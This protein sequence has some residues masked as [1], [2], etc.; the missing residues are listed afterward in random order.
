MDSER[1]ISP[2]SSKPRKRIRI[3][4][5]NQNMFDC[6]SEVHVSLLE[7]DQQPLYKAY[8]EAYANLLLLWGM[9]I[10]H[11]EVLKVEV[12]TEFHPDQPGNRQEKSS[13]PIRQEHQ[14]NE[15][16]SAPPHSYAHDGV[17][18]QHHCAKCGTA[19]LAPSNPKQNGEQLSQRKT[20]RNLPSAARC[21]QCSP[22]QPIAI[23]TACIICA[24]VIRGMFTPC[25]GCGH[26]ACL[27]CHRRWFTSAPSSDGLRGGS[28]RYQMPSCATG[29]GCHCAEHVEVEMPMPPS[30]PPPPAVTEEQPISVPASPI[31][32][33]RSPAKARR[34][35]PLENLRPGKWLHHGRYPPQFDG[36]DSRSDG[37]QEDW[38]NVSSVPLA[39]GHSSSGSNADLKPLLHHQQQHQ[40]HIRKAS[41]SQEGNGSAS[42]SVSTAASAAWGLLLE[43]VD[44]M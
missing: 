30:P 32:Q 41:T 26:V 24:E 6:D 10:Q 27:D 8:R 39:R 7:D 1:Q 3:A 15:S 38:Y 29:C 31:E 20:A 2:G 5:K 4:I 28:E 21:L 42:G 14:P 44:T 23:S 35:R 16:Y 37:Q 43:R 36:D 34:P 12:T 9:P 25:P 19:L 13:L 40:K 22:S 33:A 11:A 18:I 17:A